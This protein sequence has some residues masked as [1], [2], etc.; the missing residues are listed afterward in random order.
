MGIWLN[1]IFFSKDEY[2]R[3]NKNIEVSE[4]C[5]LENRVEYSCLA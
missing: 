2:E 4:L 3:V 5:L 1:F